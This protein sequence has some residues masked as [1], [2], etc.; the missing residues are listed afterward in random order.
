[1]K[2]LTDDDLMIVTGGSASTSLNVPC[3]FLTT[4]TKCKNNPDC[5]WFIDICVGIDDEV[6]P[7]EKAH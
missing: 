2:I 6:I 1:M 5:D 4:E 3:E 7:I